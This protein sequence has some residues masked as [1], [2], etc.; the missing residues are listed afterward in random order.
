MKKKLLFLIALTSVL[1]YSIAQQQNVYILNEADTAA[2][3]FATLYFKES[4]IAFMSN[5]NGLIHIKA[6]NL[7][8]EILVVEHLSF[9]TKEIPAT[10]LSDTI[11]LAR[12][13]YEVPEVIINN[14]SALSIIEK[15]IEAIP[16]NYI[17]HDFSLS[18]K[19]LQVHKENGK[20]V[21]FIEALTDI[22]N[23]SYSPKHQ[24]NQEESFAIKALRKSFNYERNGDQHGDHLVDLFAENPIQYL[25]KG[26]LNPKNL[27]SYTWSLSESTANNYVIHFRNNSWASS[28][29]YH[30][31]VSINKV[32]YAIV[33]VQI[34]ELPNL[35]TNI[36]NKSNWE[37]INGWYEVFFTKTTDKYA[38]SEATKWYNH[39]VRNERNRQQIDYLV[40]EVFKWQTH[41]VSPQIIDQR[42]SKN[43]NLYSLEMKYNT[44]KWNSFPIDSIIKLD[45]EH[46]LNLEEQ[47]DR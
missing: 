5:E 23:D 47:F 10:A 7:K 25:E 13:E 42:Y 4:K 11:F 24:L 28:K 16:N 41:H 6:S 20:Y 1:N 12:K 32:D 31:Y 36:E 26:V 39:Q 45:L 15:A 38:L 22:K 35:Q 40:E 18:G 3:P 27:A 2:I 17:S 44:E 46:K 34:Q 19:Y 33:K 9:R 29:N 43:S 21:R 30:G 8:N 37:F 14:L